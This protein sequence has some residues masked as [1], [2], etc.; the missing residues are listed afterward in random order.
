MVRK[1]ARQWCKEPRAGF[2]DLVAEGNIAVLKAFRNYDSTR[3]AKLST[4]VYHSINHALIAYRKA[5]SFLMHISTHHQKKEG[6]RDFAQKQEKSTRSLDASFESG[7]VTL[8]S[9]VPASGLCPCA[10]AEKKEEWEMLEGAINKILDNRERH[11]VR[12]SNK[13]FGHKTLEDLG[14]DF[15]ISRQRVHQIEQNVFAKLHR[16]LSHVGGVI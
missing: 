10:T 5:N 9:N 2:D 6:E 7:G 3:E 8:G 4:Y 16:R 13:W 15:G 12:E 1:M 11:I 14:H